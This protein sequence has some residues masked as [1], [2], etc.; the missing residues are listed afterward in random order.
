MMPMTT[1]TEAS[2]LHATDESE[3]ARAH[4]AIFSDPD[5]VKATVV[6]DLDASRAA[7]QAPVFSSPY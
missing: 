3:A 7:A 2:A 6:R 4:R 5:A 1:I